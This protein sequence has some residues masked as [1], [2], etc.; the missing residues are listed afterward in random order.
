[1]I[2]PARRLHSFRRTEE[3]AWLIPD[4]SVAVLT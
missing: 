1:M 3:A 2:A 4:R